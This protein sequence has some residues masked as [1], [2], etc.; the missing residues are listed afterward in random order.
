V[1]LPEPY[2]Q[3]DAVTIYHGDC[4]EILPSLADIDLLL[5]DPPYGMCYQHGARKGGRKMGAD[6]QKIVGDTEPFDP[7]HLLGYRQVALWGGNHFADKLPASRGWLTWDKR[8]GTPSN[9]QSDCELAWTNFLT[10][11]RLFSARWS[12]GH[13]TGREQKQ[14]R[15]HVNQKPVALMAWCIEWAGDG[16]LICD[17][18]MGSGSTLVAAKELGRMVVGIEVDEFHCETAAMRC[19]QEVLDLGAAA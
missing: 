9:D 2:Y 1:T 17:P 10:T 3:D 18:Y 14:G 6:S 7:G 13:R 15:V 11:A 8:D 12:G 16:G 19:A 4:R 5:S